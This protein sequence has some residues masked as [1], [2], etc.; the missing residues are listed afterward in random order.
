MANDLLLARNISKSFSGVRALQ[1]VSIH[2]RPAEIVC[3]IGENGSGKSTLIKIIAGVLQPDRGEIILNGRKYGS[4]TP[5]QAI[6]EGIQVIYQD[7]SLF[8][9]LTVAENIA[10]N[11]LLAQNRKIINRR[12]IDQTAR[13]ALSLIQIDVPLDACVDQIPVAEKQLVAI[14]RALLQNARLVIMD[15]PTT[16]LT[17]KEVNV[18]FKVIDKLKSDGISF[19]FV[20]HKLNEV[21]AISERIIVLRNG[22]KV[23]EDAADRFD[24]EKMTYYISGKRLENKQYIYQRNAHEQ[25]LLKVENLSLRRHFQGVSFEVY[26][27]E[28]V[29]ITGLLGS[30]R[31]SLALSLFGVKP[32]DSGRI[33]VA[34][35]P[36]HIRGIQDA[37][38]TGIGYVPEDR[39]NE[40][41]FLEKPIGTNIIVRLLDAAKG[42]NAFINPHV[43][44]RQAEHWA[45]SLAIK[46]SNLDLPARSLSGGNQQR[47]VLAKWLAS[48]P[49]LLILNGPTVG[50][51]IGSKAELHE[52]IRDLA[53]NGMGLLV[54]SDDIPELLQLCNRIFLMHRGRLVKEFPGGSVDEPTL[55]RELAEQ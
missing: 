6:R 42:I 33:A 40:G 12:E 44:C 48:K 5:I 14:S 55:T 26:P 4:L 11:Y 15:E 53:R 36:V 24:T 16:A 43:Y 41:L 52:T 50:V 28:I 7:F 23:I 18:L 10:F 8:P 20:S 9:N 46:T 47:V 35:K 29:G 25:P 38:R 3:L 2:I 1:D 39:I 22:Q 31:A 13:R 27:G 17:Q 51:D 30:G 45:H 37:I 21:Q 19:L 49:K 32:A 54:L 34:G